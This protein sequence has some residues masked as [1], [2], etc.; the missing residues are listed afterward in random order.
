MKTFRLLLLFAL[1]L[2]GCGPKDIG[3]GSSGDEFRRPLGVAPEDNLRY[4][5]TGANNTQRMLYYFNHPDVMR[6]T[7]EWQLRRY[8]RLTG[9]EIT[10]MLT[11]EDPAWREK[12]KLKSPFRQ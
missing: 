9:N 6:Q 5:A 4:A 8:S 3:T 11:P 10:P 7:R 12:P 2:P 1:L